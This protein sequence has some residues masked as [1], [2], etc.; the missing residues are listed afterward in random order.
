M[1]VQE[2]LRARKVW[3]K[4][5]PGEASRR[6]RG[7]VLCQSSECKTHTHTK[8]LPPSSHPPP[9]WT[10]NHTKRHGGRNKRTLCTGTACCKL[11]PNAI[12]GETGCTGRGAAGGCSLPPQGKGD[13]GRALP[14]HA[15]AAPPKS[16]PWLE[17]ISK[18]S[19]RSCLSKQAKRARRN[20]HAARRPNQS[21]L[22]SQRQ[23]G[24]EGDVAVAAAA[25]A[26]ARES[27][28]AP[29][30][31]RPAAKANNKGRLWSPC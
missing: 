26:A 6:L 18:D 5:S 13:R 10:R 3:K 15:L 17:G 28:C 25:A 11:T 23:G 24:G 14:V 20:R 31:Y 16:P 2:N 4:K 22:G 19:E 1:S 29:G 8:P 30:K 12:A 27:S 21:S 9:S 7:S